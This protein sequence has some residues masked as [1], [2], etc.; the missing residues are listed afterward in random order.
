LEGFQISRKTILKLL[1]ILPVAL[2][3]LLY[4]GGYIA[5]FLYNYDVWQAAGGVLGTAPE[6]PVSA[7][8]KM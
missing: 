7:S 3:A 4:G 5:Q 2:G 1:L 8:D 6:F